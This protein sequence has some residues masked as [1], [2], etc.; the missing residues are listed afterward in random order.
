MSHDSRP[1]RRVL[2]E[3]YAPLPHPCISSLVGDRSL[4]PVFSCRRIFTPSFQL[5]CP[6]GSS[7]KRTLTD[8][9]SRLFL[10]V[11]AVV[12]FGATFAPVANAAPPLFEE[13]WNAAAGTAV[14]GYNSW[15][16]TGTSVVS[17]ETIT[18]GNLSYPSY[19][20]SG[21]GNKVTLA[22]TGQE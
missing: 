20:S 11:A 4:H 2:R 14:V 19:P 21:I 10:A 7:M 6:G 15:N 3:D 9:S 13:N 17:P 16:L 12:L 8:L 5:P 1:P 22:T 18:A